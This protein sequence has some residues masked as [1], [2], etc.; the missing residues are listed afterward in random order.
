MPVVRSR[1]P[2]RAA[3]GQILLGARMSAAPFILP[4]PKRAIIADPVAP[5]IPFRGRVDRKTQYGRF[6]VFC[7]TDQKWIVFDPALPFA[8]NAASVHPNKDA[9]CDDAE[10]RSAAATARGEAN[11]V[12]RHGFKWDWSLPETWNR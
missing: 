8:H 2:L 10:I 5:V 11:E 12:E 9:A 1:M 6:S 7:R 4:S 3:Q